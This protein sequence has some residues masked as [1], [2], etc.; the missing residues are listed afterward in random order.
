MFIWTAKLNKKKAAGVLAAAVVLCAAAAAV[1]LAGRQAQASA[2]V[3]PKGIRSEEDRV[4]YLQ[5]WGW[6]VNPQAALVE[7]LEL[8]EEFGETYS[9]YLALQTGQG[10]DLEKHAG[11]RVRRYT[12][13]ILNYPTGGDRCGGPS[14]GAEK[15]RHRR[16]GHRRVLP[17]RAGHTGGIEGY[18]RPYQKKGRSLAGTP[19]F[20]RDKGR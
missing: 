2:M 13:E 12:Y 9:Q 16:G 10:F 8:P 1:T 4:A 15:Y 18:P 20:Y 11:K 7:E 17:P 6:Q 14:A 19:L 5:E 3:S